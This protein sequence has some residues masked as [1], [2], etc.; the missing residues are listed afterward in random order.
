[1]DTVDRVD[2]G[3]SNLDTSKVTAGKLAGLRQPFHTC[4]DTG[5]EETYPAELCIVNHKKHKLYFGIKRMMDIALSVLAIIVLTP[6]F[7]CTAAA[8]KLETNGKVIFQQAR[9]GKDGK[10]FKM[11]KFRSMYE[12]SEK[13]RYDRELLEKN[14]MDGPVFKISDDPRVTK[15]GKFIRKT[16][17]D[18]LPQLLNIIKGDMSIVGPRPFAVYETDEFNDY[19]NLRHQV[20][21][22]LTCYWQISGRNN[23]PY[24]KWISYDMKY[25]QKMNIQTDIKIILHTVSVVFTGKGAY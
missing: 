12:D 21:P 11:Y 2:L 10:V 14:E 25:L 7:F 22:G 19:D 16:S 3:I 23:I 4:L 15:V 6:L 5:E 17:I 20:K 24:E 8:I 13:H 18:E 1:L 9:T